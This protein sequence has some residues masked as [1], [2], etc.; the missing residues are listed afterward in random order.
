M[1]LRIE[2]QR[3]NSIAETLYPFLPK[4]PLVPILENILL[5]LKDNELIFTASD[6][7]NAIQYKLPV[8]EVEISEPQDVCFNILF[9]SD[10]VKSLKDETISLEFFDNGMVITHDSGHIEMA[11]EDVKMYPN[12][13][14]LE[15]ESFIKIT[16][17]EFYNSLKLA[18]SIVNPDNKDYQPSYCVHFNGKD[19]FSSG[20]INHTYFNILKVNIEG[21]MQKVSVHYSQIQKLL[22]YISRRSEF[23]IHFGIDHIVCKDEYSICYIAGIKY[24]A[25]PYE[26]IYKQETTQKVIISKKELESCVNRIIVSSKGFPA[27]ISLLS[28]DDTIEISSLNSVYGINISET[29]SAVMTDNIDYGLLANQLIKGFK[30]FDEGNLTIKFFQSVASITCESNENIFVIGRYIFNK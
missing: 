2:K 18:N 19:I 8:D 28:H 30:M 10:Y 17:N 3:L 7:N 27:Y 20:T 6:S 24:S 13:E 9:A 1:K 25:P 29:I 12:R 21:D 4:N 11:T 16:G 14:I 5:Q 15:P 23:K 26:L 22:G